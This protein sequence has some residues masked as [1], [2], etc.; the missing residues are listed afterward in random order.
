MTRFILPTIGNL[1]LLT[2]G[3]SD[4]VAGFVVRGAWIG[5]PAYWLGFVSQET[6]PRIAMWHLF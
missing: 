2:I 5:A 1:I 4:T 3:V 6:A